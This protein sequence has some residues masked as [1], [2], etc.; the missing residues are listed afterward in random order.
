[1]VA[2]A[3]PLFGLGTGAGPDNDLLD[4]TERVAP[5]LALPLVLSA[6]F[7]QFSAATADTVAAAGNLRGMIASMTSSRAY[8]LSGVAAIILS[9]TVDTFVIITIASRAF[10]AYYC[11]QAII[12]FRTSSGPLRKAL[13]AL[14]ALV[15]AA[16]TL[17]AEPVG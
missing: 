1:F 6:V 7:S 2:V 10:A 9:W 15:L 4:I 16:I 3:T 12:A 14:L 11:L 17:L 8:L 13:Y 5:L